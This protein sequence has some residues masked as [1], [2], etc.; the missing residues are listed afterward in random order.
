MVLLHTS[1][2]VSTVV[3]NATTIRV[4]GDRFDFA[5]VLATPRGIGT[6]SFLP[7]TSTLVMCVVTTSRGCRT[8]RDPFS[9]SLRRVFRPP[10]CFGAPGIPQVS[11]FQLTVDWR[12]DP[13][14]RGSKGKR[15]DRAVPRPT[16]NAPSRSTCASHACFTRRFD[17]E[18]PPRK[19]KKH[20]GGVPEL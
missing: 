12:G 20:V 4:C 16:T 8:I 5:Q 13:F 14:S 1:F 9:L 2:F 11:P 18:P 19:E 15:K 17:F 10:F 7:F 3:S 6:T